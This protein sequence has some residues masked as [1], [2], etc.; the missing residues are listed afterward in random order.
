MLKNPSSHAP[1]LKE[2]WAQVKKKDTRHNKEF[3]YGYRQTKRTNNNRFQY[4]IK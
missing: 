3:L 2:K 4:D 1:T